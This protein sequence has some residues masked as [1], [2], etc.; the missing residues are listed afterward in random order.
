MPI[1]SIL[2]FLSKMAHPEIILLGCFSNR[3]IHK[4]L[5]LD[6]PLYD[7]SQ[8]KFDG[9]GDTS[10]TEHIF[11]L[12]KFCESYEIDCQDVACVLLFLTLEGCVNELW[13]TL[14]LA[15]V[16]LFEQFLNELHQAFDRYDY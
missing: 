1:E 11:L 7:L 2:K 16:H 6:E 3:S 14:S 4:I 13:Y 12:F 15:S 10:I 8:L 5:I 9:E